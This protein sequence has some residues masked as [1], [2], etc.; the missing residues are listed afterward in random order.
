MPTPIDTSQG[1]VG[2]N[3]V[4]WDHEGVNTAGPRLSYRRHS[5]ITVAAV[6]AIIGGLS[7]ATWAQ[8]LL[9]LLIIPLG[10][11]VWGWRSGT[12][13]D[14]AGVTVRAAVG[15]RRIPWSGV[16][17]IA[18]DARG[19]VVAYLT[20]GAVITLPAMTPKDLAGLVAASG[21]ELVTEPQVNPTES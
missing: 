9:P 4:G 18:T 7:L 8:Y 19:R 10:V 2:P 21:Q 12:D 20:S 14:T 13:V 3:R 17:Q 15:T 5:A 1:H 6:I 11:A 16:A